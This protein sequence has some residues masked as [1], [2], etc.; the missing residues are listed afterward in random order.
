MKVTK[1]KGLNAKPLRSFFV[2]SHTRPGGPPG[3]TAANRSDS[4]LDAASLRFGQG[5][6]DSAR[7]RFCEARAVECAAGSMCRTASKWPAGPGFRSVQ[8]A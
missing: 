1:A 2:A 4:S 6:S 3:A 8:N 5:S 7:A